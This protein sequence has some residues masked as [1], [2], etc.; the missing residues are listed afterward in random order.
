MSKSIEVVTQLK[1]ELDVVA[2]MKEEGFPSF[3]W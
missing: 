3:R 1:K 2:E